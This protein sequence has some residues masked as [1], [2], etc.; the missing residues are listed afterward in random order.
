MKFKNPFNNKTHNLID[1]LND[2][3][4]ELMLH[5]TGSSTVNTMNKIRLGSNMEGGTLSEVVSRCE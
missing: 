4:E 1:Y 5:V 2:P 3:E